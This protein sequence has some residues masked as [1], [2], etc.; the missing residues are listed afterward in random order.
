MEARLATGA[1]AGPA[2]AGALRAVDAAVHRTIGGCRCCSNMIK[3]L[4]AKRAASEAR[5]RRRIWHR[6]CR[7]ASSTHKP[8]TAA[9]QSQSGSDQ[10][11][12]LANGQTTSRSGVLANVQMCRPSLQ[13]CRLATQHLSSRSPLAM[14][15]CQGL[16]CWGCLIHETRSFR[17]RMLWHAP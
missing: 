16:V 6:E 9:L 14:H 2:P 4:P 12:G 5:G 7:L 13:S 10:A 17:R 1:G 8:R 11:A 3:L 15:C